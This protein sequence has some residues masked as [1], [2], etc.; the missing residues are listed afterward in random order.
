MNLGLRDA[1]ELAATIIARG[2]QTDCGDYLLL[3]RYERARKE[4]ILAMELATDGLQ[5]LFNNTNPT[6]VRWRNLGLEITNRLPLIK[7]RLMQ[8]AL[9]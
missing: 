6:L 3:R 4:D 9:S 8:H 5:K 7:D 1:R 2:I